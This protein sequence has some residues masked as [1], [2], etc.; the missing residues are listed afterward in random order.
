M[1]TSTPMRATAPARITALSTEQCY[2]RNRVLILGGMDASMLDRW[3]RKLHPQA[4]AV[5]CVQGDRL[6][7]AV[8]DPLAIDEATVARLGEMAS[9]WRCLGLTPPLVRIAPQRRVTSRR[10]QF[11]LLP[12]TFGHRCAQAS[13]QGRQE[14][15][16]SGLQRPEGTGQARNL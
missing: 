16:L 11:G 4:D 2:P 1:Y 15:G 8:K 12:S 10:R 9:G 7:S 13:D 14:L 3:R 5:L 6:L